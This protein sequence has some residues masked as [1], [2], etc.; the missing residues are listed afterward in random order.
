MKSCAQHLS[1]AIHKIVQNS[2]FGENYLPSDSHT[3]TVIVFF[4]CLPVKMAS[5]TVIKVYSY[6]TDVPIRRCHAFQIFYIQT[7]NPPHRSI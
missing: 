1:S 7:K 4:S 6:C 3:N 5:E 2:T